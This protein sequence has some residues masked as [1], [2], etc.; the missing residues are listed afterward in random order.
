MKIREKK[1]GKS[2]R[3]SRSKMVRILS[4]PVRWYMDFE[5]KRGKC[6]RKNPGKVQT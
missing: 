4:V 2:E 6:F 3:V 5:G 1:A